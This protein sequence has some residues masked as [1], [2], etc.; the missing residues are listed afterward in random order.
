MRKFLMTMAWKNYIWAQPRPAKPDEIASLEQFWSVTLP[1]DYKRVVSMHQGM[2]PHPNAFTIGRGENVIAALLIISPDEQQRAYS[3]T[4]T[5][6]QI[7]PHVPHGIYPFAV[8]GTGDC[9]CFDYRGSLRSPKIVFYFSESA[10]E[11]SLYPLAQSFSDLLAKLH[12]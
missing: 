1:D 11:E 5:Y 4:G 7:K 10:D 3:I 9:I 8:T 12:D 2:S 6:T